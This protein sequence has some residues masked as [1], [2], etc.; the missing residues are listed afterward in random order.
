MM[1][2]RPSVVAFAMAVGLTGLVTAQGARGTQPA[3]G[4]QGAPQVTQG[5][6]GPDLNLKLGLWEMSAGVDIASTGIDLSKL[7]A[8]Q[9]AQMES[10]MRGGLVMAPMAIKQCMTKEKLATHSYTVAKDG[11]SCKQTIVRATPT[12]VDMTQVCTGPQGYTNNVHIE[13]PTPTSMTVTNK[14]SGGPTGQTSTTTIGK[15]VAADCGDVK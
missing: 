7:P 12:M 14:M 10:V 5:P 9:R 6:Q 3:Q 8:D 1:R 4:T 15:W 2:V 13:A 11:L